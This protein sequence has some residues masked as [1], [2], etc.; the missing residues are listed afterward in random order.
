MAHNSGLLGSKT[1]STLSTAI[2][3]SR[4]EYWDTT[5]LLSE[6]QR[7]QTV[8]T[9][10]QSKCYTNGGSF[11][12]APLTYQALSRHIVEYAHIA[13][14]ASSRREAAEESY[15]VAAL[16]KA[17]LSSKSTGEDISCK[18]CRKQEACEKCCAV[19]VRLGKALEVNTSW[20]LYLD[21]FLCSFGESIWYNS[22][23]YASL[24]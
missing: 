6:L 2:G 16:I 8:T 19:L 18:T 17:S 20:E 9:C 23:M 10:S 22:S 7:K 13:H 15:V 24:Q 3:E 12:R 1:L 5:L 4:F 14:T 11:A 21:S